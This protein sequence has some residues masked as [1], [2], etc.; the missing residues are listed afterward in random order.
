VL[1]EGKEFCSPQHANTSWRREKR[2]AARGDAA[3]V[4]PQTRALPAAPN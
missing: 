4:K 3:K 1:R 2:R